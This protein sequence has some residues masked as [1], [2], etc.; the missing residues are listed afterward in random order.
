MCKKQSELIK[1]S[2][3]I[4]SPFEW[5]APEWR[6]KCVMYAQRSPFA[7]NAPNWYQRAQQQT[8]TDD[9][10]DDLVKRTLIRP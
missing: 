1:R 8:R 6:P 5:L 3:P 4:V 7:G 2:L 9:I 10:C